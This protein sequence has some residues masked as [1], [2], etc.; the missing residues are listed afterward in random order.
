MTDAIK[1]QAK[2]AYV[3]ATDGQQP[4]EAAPA[5]Q[6]TGYDDITLFEPIA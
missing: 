4:G 5:R 2:D 3:Y 6:W 1:E